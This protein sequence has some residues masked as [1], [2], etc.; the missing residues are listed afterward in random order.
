MSVSASGPGGRVLCGGRPD[1]WFRGNGIQ[2][3]DEI[4]TLRATRWFAAVIET[5]RLRIAGQDPWIDETS[6]NQ[7]APLGF[8]VPGRWGIPEILG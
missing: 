5:W 8:E 6:R 2:R 1:A 4:G 7:T 3:P